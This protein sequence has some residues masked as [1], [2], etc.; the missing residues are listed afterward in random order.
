[1]VQMKV[2]KLRH[3][4][5]GACRTHTREGGS[6]QAALGS[7][8]AWGRT[9]ARTRAPVPVQSAHFLLPGS[10]CSS[11]SAF[12]RRALVFIVPAS[13]VRAPAPGPAASTA[14]PAQLGARAKRGRTQAKSVGALRD[15][16]CGVA[17]NCHIE[18]DGQ[19]G[20]RWFAADT[21]IAISLGGAQWVLPLAAAW[22]WYVAESSGSRGFGDA[23]L[24]AAA[25]SSAAMVNA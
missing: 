9:H 25:P 5:C 11:F 21:G 22:G 17:Q 1:M 2:E 7:P 3:T 19:A 20:L 16:L 6:A 24:T 4:Y 8:P 15:G 12:S 10:F 14:T 18:G 23:S 13:H